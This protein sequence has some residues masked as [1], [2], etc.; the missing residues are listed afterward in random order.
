[1]VETRNK[2]QASTQKATKKSKTDNPRKKPVKPKSTNEPP[3]PSVNHRFLNSQ[4]RDRLKDIKHYRVILERAFLL[5]KLLKNPEFEQALTAWDWHGLNG[6]IFE[7]ANKTL[8]LEFYVNARFSRRRYGSYVRGKD[9]DFSPEAI[10]NLLKI[11]PPEQCDVKRRRETCGNWNDEA[12]EELLLQMCVEGATWKGGK[13]ML[14]KSDFKP[15]SKAW[16]SFVVQT[17]EDTSCSSEIPLVRVHTI[18]AIM[19]GAPI[20]VGEL[21]ANNIADFATGNKKALLI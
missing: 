20:N 13:R 9:I 12:W 21:I 2:G 4:A 11:V 18:A 16:A 17:L 6:M 10:N 15:V 3:P 19:D 1:M 8:A 14:L 7:Q 5:P